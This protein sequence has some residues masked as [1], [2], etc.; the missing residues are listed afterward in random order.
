MNHNSAIPFGMPTSR[1]PEKT[2][3]G[4]R[5]P[6]SP[7]FLEQ[8]RRSVETGLGMSWSAFIKLSGLSRATEWRVV[9]PDTVSVLSLIPLVELYAAEAAKRGVK[10]VPVKPLVFGGMPEL[11]EWIDLG[12]RLLRANHEAFTQQVGKIRNAVETLE[13]LS[14]DDLGGD[15]HP[16]HRP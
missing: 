15:L 7:D 12:E 4:A 3:A 9:D 10:D 5:I 16:T 8:F 14:S 1:K 6:I 11:R 13:D 2:E